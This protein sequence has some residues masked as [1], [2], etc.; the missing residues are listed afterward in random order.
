ML[1]PKGGGKDFHRIGLVEV[2][3]KAT[4]G[5]I[6]QRL[7]VAI[8]YYDS[9]HGLQMGRGTRTSI[10]EADLPHKLKSMREEVLHNVF[11]D[12]HKVYNALDRDRYL[13]ILT[14]YGVGPQTL[15][16][17]S[18]YWTRIWMDSKYGGY[19]GPPFQ[20]YCGVTQVDPLSPMVFN[21]V[22][23]AVIC[24]KVMVAVRMDTGL[25]VLED[26]IQELAAFS[27]VD[28]GLIESPCMESF[29]R[30]FN[31]LADLFG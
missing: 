23:G 20:G 2:M 13:N 14:G 24:H 11:L 25:E 16:I 12:L 8:T 27:Y 30:A 4:T 29:Q 17:L 6:N 9:I 18:T 21:M 26:T 10:L 1:I 3:W 5:I 7:T 22:V 28:Y 15:W 19:S 31:V